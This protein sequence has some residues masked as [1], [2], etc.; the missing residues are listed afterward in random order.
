VKTDT[1][2]AKRERQREA[3]KRKAEQKRAV[4]GG[5]RVFLRE[6]VRPTRLPGDADPI[7][8]FETFFEKVDRERAKAIHPIVRLTENGVDWGVIPRQGDEIGYGMHPYR[9]DDCLR[10]AIATA[11]QIPVEDVPDLGLDDRL[12][13]GEEPDE[14][15][16]AV[17]AQVQRWA[18]THELAMRFWETL[19]APRDR[20]IGVSGS[21]TAAAAEKRKG[22]SP[23][24]DHCLV[25]CRDR[26]LFNPV[27]SVVPPPGTEAG[28]Y[29]Y[30][31]TYGI[32]F[33]K[34]E[35]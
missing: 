20:W 12:D 23:F 15:G 4:L 2:R 17:W 1:K 10:A 18:A 9:V 5:D 29:R 7:P 3:R 35:R 25:M 24:L 27:C 13:R 21:G 11:T 19:P 14:V 6:P 30:S 22:A 32:S 26:I 34:K 16:L 31:F 8:I 28:G 33:D